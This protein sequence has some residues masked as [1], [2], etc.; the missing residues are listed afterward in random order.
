[1]NAGK[2][3]AIQIMEKDEYDAEI[4][5]KLTRVDGPGGKNDQRMRRYHWKPINGPNVRPNPPK[6]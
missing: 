2:Q 6:D 3:N 4:M 1:M 5:D